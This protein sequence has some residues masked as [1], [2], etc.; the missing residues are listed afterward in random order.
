[1][2]ELG[3]NI[4][5]IEQIVKSK[6][7]ISMETVTDQEIE[8]MLK[9][10]PLIFDKNQ[11]ITDYGTK[12]FEEIQNSFEDFKTFLPCLNYPGV[13]TRWKEFL[14]YLLQNKTLKTPKEAFSGFANHL[15]RVTSYRALSLTEQQFQNILESNEVFP[16]G[17]LKVNEEKLRQ[18]VDENG[19]YKICYARLYIG[20]R[21]VEFDPSV[22]LHDDPETAVCIA[23]G[24]TNKEKK[25]HLM[26]L[27]IPKIEACGY[28]LKEVQDETQMH[29]WFQFSGVWFDARLERT[30]RYV[31]YGI[32]FL[33]ERLQELKIFENEKEIVEFIKPFKENQ[34][35]LRK[36]EK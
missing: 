6:N 29:D 31:L 9:N 21:L 33:K 3:Q 2:I 23:N 15:G 24:Y 16:S 18:I 26:K 4:L 30:E 12:I 14:E 32:P 36:K 20:M 1:M 22:S 11:L 25:I 27:K 7:N 28:K 35:E 34:I 10:R 17:R 5:K 8:Q 19:V 13:G